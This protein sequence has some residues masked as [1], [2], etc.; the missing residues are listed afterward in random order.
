[1]TAAPT[2]LASVTRSPQAAAHGGS[3]DVGEASGG[4]EGARVELAGDVSPARA[5]PWTWPRPWCSDPASRSSC[6]RLANRGTCRGG[7]CSCPRVEE[8]DPVRPWRLPCA[9]LDALDLL[10][11]VAH[12]TEDGA[13]QERV[14]W[15]GEQAAGRAALLERLL[16]ELEVTVLL[17]RPEPPAPLRF[18]AGEELA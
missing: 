15:H 16:P 9:S 8:P 4:V 11:I 2:R 5:H 18:E 1:M 6:C 17:V 3:R 7:A 12:V 13:A 14:G 10:V